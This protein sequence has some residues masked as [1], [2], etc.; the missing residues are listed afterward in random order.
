M[1]EAFLNE[2]GLRLSPE[3]TKV[4]HITEG[5]D[6]LGQNIRSYNGGVLVTPSKKNAL[7]FLAKI[8]ELINANKGASHEKL[9]RVLNPVIRGWA[10]Y[11]RH[12]SAK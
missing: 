1:I 4:T 12:I 9:I 2:R 10:N 3:K 5:I 6:F 8:R 11:H 7:S